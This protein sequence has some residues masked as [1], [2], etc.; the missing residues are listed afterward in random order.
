[1]K[2]MAFQPNT[3]VKLM[4]GGTIVTDWVRAFRRPLTGSRDVEGDAVILEDSFL[5]KLYDLATS[6]MLDGREWK[7]IDS[8]GYVYVVE[9][10]SVVKGNLIR[11]RIVRDIG[12]GRM[13]V[14][15]IGVTFAAGNQVVFSPWSGFCWGAA[16]A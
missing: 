13:P 4:V 15:G 7:V 16:N 10:V 2:R 12:S 1:M 3:S 14:D 5:I 8:E 9:Y 6:S 11:C